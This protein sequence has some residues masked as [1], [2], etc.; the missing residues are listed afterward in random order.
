MLKYGFSV[1]QLDRE[2]QLLFMVLGVL[3]LMLI[4]AVVTHQKVYFIFFSCQKS[5]MADTL[6]SRNV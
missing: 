4:P 5:V 6:V 1:R 2:I 3:L